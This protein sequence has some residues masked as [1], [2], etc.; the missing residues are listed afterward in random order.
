M[1]EVVAYKNSDGTYSDI[2]SE[3][4]SPIKK[5]SE[6]ALNIMSHIMSHNI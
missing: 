6:D 5:L 4:S 3:G 2:N 1:N